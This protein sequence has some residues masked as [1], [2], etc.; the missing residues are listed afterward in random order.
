MSPLILRPNHTVCTLDGS[1]YVM[2]R[3][4]HGADLRQLKICGGNLL[5]LSLRAWIAH[6][7]SLSQ[8]RIRVSAEEVSCVALELILSSLVDVPEAPELQCLPEAREG[9]GAA[10][11][12]VAVAVAVVGVYRLSLRALMARALYLS[13]RRIRVSAEEVSCAAP[14]LIL[15]NL[16]DAPQ[17][18]QPQFRQKAHPGPPVAVV[19]VAVAVAGA[20]SCAALL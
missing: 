17:A 11:V 3:L 7:S 5:R 1:S 2:L 16:V 12:A 19:D 6:A 20:V 14:A 4:R 13:P 15:I 18:L 8:R 10:A 9:G